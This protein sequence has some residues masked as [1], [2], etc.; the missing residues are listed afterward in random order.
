MNTRKLKVELRW[1][2]ELGFDAGLAATVQWYVDHRTWWERVLTEAYQAT[3]AMYLE[4]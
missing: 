3:N 2:P 4:D 1:R